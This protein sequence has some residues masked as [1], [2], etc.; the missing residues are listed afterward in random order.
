MAKV[1]NRK[2]RILTAQV[3]DGK[4][5]NPVPAI[6]ITPDIAS[7]LEVMQ[8]LSRVFNDETEE[9]D[10]LFDPD[11]VQMVGK[12]AFEDAVWDKSTDVDHVYKTLLCIIAKQIVK[13][14][15]SRPEPDA[16]LSEAAFRASVEA[17]MS[18]N[19]MSVDEAISVVNQRILIQ[20]IGKLVLELSE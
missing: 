11:F 17:V 15:I 6:E 9:Y 8:K 5:E 12:I 14:V 3:W 13:S 19:G 20:K 2:T 18:N 10:Q 4:S 16:L 7:W 1:F